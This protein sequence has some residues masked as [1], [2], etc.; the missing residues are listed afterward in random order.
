MASSPVSPV[1]RSTSADRLRAGRLPPDRWY[2]AGD[3]V[4]AARLVAL[5]SGLTARVV[6]AGPID[7]APVVLVHGWACSAY[8]YRHLLPV[9]AAAGYRAVAPDLKGHGLSDKPLDPHSYSAEAMAAFVGELVTALGFDRV[10]LV[11][12][13]LGGGI[14]ARALLEGVVRAERLAVVSAI[15]FGTVPFMPLLRYVPV[16]LIEPFL[17][18]LVARWL[19]RIILYSVVA[20]RRSVSD[21][22]LEQYWAPSRFPEFPR[23]ALRLIREYHWD[24]LLPEERARLGVPVLAIFGDRDHVV[25]RRAEGRISTA[26]VEAAEL[27]G[28]EA[29]VL[30]G[31]GH[32][33]FD[34]AP[35]DVHPLLLGFLEPW[36]RAWSGAAVAGS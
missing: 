28:L 33:P 7:G 36:R 21:P 4:A 25:R 13:S 27:G 16:P 6:E 26:V 10:A 22:D 24:A 18:A 5:P 9:L 8:T 35:A 3:A 15:G 11:G 19:Y 31:V 23:A 2:P 20:R 1:A 32:M 30:R 34:E 29:H 12:H 14:A 17:P